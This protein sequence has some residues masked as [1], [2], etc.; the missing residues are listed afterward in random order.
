MDGCTTWVLKLASVLD[1]ATCLP[2]LRYSTHFSITL[3][4][5]LQVTQLPYAVDVHLGLASVQWMGLIQLSASQRAEAA[6]NQKIKQ[7]VK[8]KSINPPVPSVRAAVLTREPQG[9]ECTSTGY[10][11]QSGPVPR[12][13][14]WGEQ[15]QLHLG[16]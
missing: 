1:S 4:F 13:T 2:G 7:P 8:N 11:Q 10:I 9:T 6:V 12:D 5:V 3:Q 15:Q 16:F 14:L